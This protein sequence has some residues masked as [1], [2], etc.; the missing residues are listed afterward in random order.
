MWRIRSEFLMRSVRDVV[1][2]YTTV[3]DGRKVQWFQW[4]GYDHVYNW[5]ARGADGSHL[6]A[7]LQIK[8]ITLSGQGAD[9]RA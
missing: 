2:G 5:H 6:S 9:Q 1:I 8:K 7:L 3:M 4:D